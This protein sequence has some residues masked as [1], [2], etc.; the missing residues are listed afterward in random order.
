MSLPEIVSREEW[1][2]ARKAHLAREKEFTRMRDE[3]T[4]ERRRLPMVRIE[5]D[6]RFTGA[7]GEVGLAD[8]FEGRQPADRRPLHVRPELGGRLPELHRGCRRDRAP[9]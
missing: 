8:L 2:G 1:L 5:K 7:D 3:L 9:G 4:A 6:Y